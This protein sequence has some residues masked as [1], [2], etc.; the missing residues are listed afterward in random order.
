MQYRFSFSILECYLEKK[1][2]I[3]RGVFLS[4]W[5]GQKDYCSSIFQ[6]PLLAGAARLLLFSRRAHTLTTGPAGGN[7][8]P[9]QPECRGVGCYFQRSG[10]GCALL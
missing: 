9:P 1:S 5:Q 10:P 6:H 8:L 3:F 2:S 4:E 7:L